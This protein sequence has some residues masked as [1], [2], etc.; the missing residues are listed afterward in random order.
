MLQRNDDVLLCEIR[1]DY[2]SSDYEF[3]VASKAGRSETVRFASATALIDGYLRWQTALRAH[4]WR[5][6]LVHGEV[7]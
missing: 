5:P 6:K 1:Q 2:T 7:A 3:A 4:G